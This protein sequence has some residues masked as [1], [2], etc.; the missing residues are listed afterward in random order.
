MERPRKHSRWSS[1]AGKQR[2]DLW[3]EVMQCDQFIGNGYPALQHLSSNPGGPPPFA[4]VG[5]AQLQSLSTLKPQWKRWKKAPKE[6]TH[7]ANKTLLGVF[8][9][10]IT[11]M[12]H[13]RVTLKILQP[14]GEQGSSN[15]A[16]QEIVSPVQSCLQHLLVDSSTDKQ[17]WCYGQDHGRYSGA[18]T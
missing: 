14:Q 7:A 15:N 18:H 13:L 6:D 3:W 4:T 5:Q 10:N 2:V 11:T 9:K 8:N 12:R 17:R 16:Y 1:S